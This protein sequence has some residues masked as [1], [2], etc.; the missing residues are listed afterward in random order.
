MN[1]SRWTLL[2]MLAFIF[3]VTTTLIPAARVSAAPD[4]QI[5]LAQADDEDDWDDWDDEEEEDAFGNIMHTT[6]LKIVD[7]K[8]SAPAAGQPVK[9][10]ATFE[11]IG[12]E[13]EEEDVV[14]ESAKI[15]YALNGDLKGKQSV[16]MTCSGTTCTGDIPGQSGGT[17]TYGVVA[18]DNFGNTTMEAFKVGAAP[19]DALIASTPDIDNSGD[20]VPDDMDLIGASFAYDDERL[21]TGFDVQGQ[22]SGGTIDPPYIHFYGIKMTN[23]D[24]EQS[25]GLMVGKLWVN[26]P[27]AKDK[28]V[29]EKFM[30]LLLQAKEYTDQLPEGSLERVMETGMLV[31]DIGKLMS[32]NIMDGLLFDALP[33]G[34]ITGG[35]KF[36]GSVKRSALGDNPSNFARVIMLTAANASIDSFM[37]I[38]LNCSHYAQIYFQNHS[39]SIGGAAPV[40]AAGGD[41]NAEIASIKKDMAALQDK[42]AKLE[43]MKA[44]PPTGLPG[45]MTFHGYLRGRVHVPEIENTTFEATEIAFQPRWDASDKIHGEAHLWFYPFAPG[46]NNGVYIENAMMIFDDMGIGK[47]SKLILG[48]SRNMAYGITPTGGGRLLSNY[49]LYSDSF[50]HDRL[51]GIHSLNKLDNGKVDLNFAIVNGY[52]VGRRPVGTA[53]IS[54]NNA[55]DPH[56]GGID[57]NSTRVLANREDGDALDGNNNRGFSLRLGGNTSKEFNLGA[58]MYTARLTDTD[59]TNLN[60]FTGFTA[61]KRRHTM[62]GGD[63]RLTSDPWIWQVE[64]TDAD[65][66]GFKYDGFQTVLGYNFD[67]I[68]FLY[69]QYGMVDY[70]ITPVATESATWDKQQL[71]I[72]FKH[73]LSKT[74]WLT[75]EHEFNEEDPPTGT[76]EVGNNL[77]FLEY[78]VG[79]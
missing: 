49:S 21:Y 42:L 24:I 74:S 70:D 25:E 44:S 57:S 37:P 64:Y 63:F 3:T 30:P 2:L 59:A 67:N 15:V 7:V 17:V 31:L 9:V 4:D 54:G 18:A 66:G 10:T 65:M 12:A 60:G 79:Y 47:G 32:G 76:S 75:L 77:T 19:A 62:Y 34:E 29:Q 38:P 33:D 55:D 69:L 35:N 58:S 43:A 46:T 6:Y 14:V 51:V 41:V 26:L 52:T 71:S 73:K 68:N 16:A 20:I 13:D 61:T 53:L 50:H 45:N 22:I 39:Y 11:I 27:L 28:A 48:K 56:A 78:F 8:N 5:V 1:F 23:P 40:V 72:S 36:V